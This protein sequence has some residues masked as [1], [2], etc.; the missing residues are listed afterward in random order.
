MNVSWGGLAPFTALVAT[1]VAMQSAVAATGAIR[2]RDYRLFEYSS[3]ESF[4]REFPL[5]TIDHS[6]AEE[7]WQ[8]LSSLIDKM[9]KAAN[10]AQTTYHHAVVRSA[11]CLVLAFLAMVLG[12]ISQQDWPRTSW[13]LTDYQ[14]IEHLLTWIDAITIVFVLVLFL[15]ARS[16]GHRWIAARVGT[17]LL[18]QHQFLNLIFP[19]ANAAPQVANVESQFDL[20]VNAVRTRVQEGSVADIVSRIERFWSERRTSTEKRV[21]A[22][23]DI[24]ASALLTYLD[25]RARRQ[26]GWF[27]DSKAR[28][29]HIAKR[30]NIVLLSL[31]GVAVGLAVV[32]LALFLFSG[33]SPAYLMPPLLI[34]TGMSAAVTA[35]YFNQ[36]ARSLIHRYNTQQRQVTEWLRAFNDRWKFATLPSLNLNTAMKSEIC[37]SILRFEDLMIEELIDWVH[38]TSHDAIELAP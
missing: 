21:L 38:I 6:T 19:G 32:K 2:R 14:A 28:L 22:G 8:A 16:A 24:P 13:P 12:T 1:L 26:L 15:Y 3:K 34:V 9:H 10:A 30:R 7:S 11:G 36:N 20:E 23:S 33:H 29:E 27:A 4:A 31:Y 25:R 18:R 37:A 17:E 35:Y 5:A